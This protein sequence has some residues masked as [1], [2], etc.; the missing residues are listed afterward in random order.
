LVG[1]A[2]GRARMHAERGEPD[3]VTRFH[4][5]GSGANR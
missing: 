2:A 4:D 3:P 1:A 5:L